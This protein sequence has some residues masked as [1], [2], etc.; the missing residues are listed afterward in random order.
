MASC[1]PGQVLELRGELR[2]E[3][4][5]EAP[6]DERLGGWTGVVGR[7]LE[8]LG[9][10]GQ[11]RDPVVELRPECAGLQLLALPGREVGVLEVELRQR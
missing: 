6:T 2:L 10:V 1:S 3:V 11:L 7:Q 4:E 8:Q 9:G 5:A